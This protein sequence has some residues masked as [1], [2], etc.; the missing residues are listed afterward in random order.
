MFQIAKQTEGPGGAF[1]KLVHLESDDF[2]VVVRYPSDGRLHQRYIGPDFMKAEEIY[3]LE[4]AGFL[5][6][7]SEG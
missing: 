4:S 5:R 6:K 7:G 2:A 3:G 1:V